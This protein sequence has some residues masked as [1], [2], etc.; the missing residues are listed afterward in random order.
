[1]GRVRPRAGRPSSAERKRRAFISRGSAPSWSSTVAHTWACS[2]SRSAQ[3]G[4][5]ASGPSP[6]ASA[7]ST[8]SAVSSSSRPTRSP[9]PASG[10]ATASRP[11]SP[12]SPSISAARMAGSTGGSSSP[13]I[14]SST[15]TAFAARCRRAAD[16]G[17]SLRESLHEFADIVATHPSRE[18]Q[19]S[20]GG[21]RAAGDLTRRL[22]QKRIG[23]PARVHR[24]ALVISTRSLSDAAR[25]CPSPRPLATPVR[26]RSTASRRES[27]S[28]SIPPILPGATDIPAAVL[29][30]SD[31]ESGLI[32]RG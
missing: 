31:D 13:R 24:R 19:V 3:A 4:G 12:T 6:R 27:S 30:S 26:V 16:A 29:P 28:A 7:A 1:M 15:I 9:R 20:V 11:S 2:R 23:E 32:S 25:I 10:P 8:A 14:D 5:A 18:P 17:A 21:L 22:D